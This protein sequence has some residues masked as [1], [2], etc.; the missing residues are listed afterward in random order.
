MVGSP[1]TLG[2]LRRGECAIEIACNACGH[3]ELLDREVT[4]HERAGARATSDWATFCREQKCW[5]CGA[6][7]VRVMPAPFSQNNKELRRRRAQNTLINLALEVLNEAARESK[8]GTVGTPEVRLAL[9]V[10]HPFLRDENLLREYWREA[11]EE[12]RR[13]WTGCHLPFRWIVTGLVERGFGV[14]AEFR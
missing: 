4:I 9:R 11:T 14:N 12:P 1:K 10:L 3:A 8:K 13:A 5:K 7:D 2:D 6:D